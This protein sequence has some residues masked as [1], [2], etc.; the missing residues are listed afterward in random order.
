MAIALRPGRPQA[1]P[2]L[3]V[4]HL[5]VDLVRGRQRT[6]IVR[7]LSFSLEAGQKTAI[8]GE[9]GAGKSVTARAIAGLLDR[10]RFA[11]RGEIAIDGINIVG[12]S[13]R[14]QQRNFNRVALVFQDPTRTLNPT[15]RVGRQIAEAITSGGR[16]QARTAVHARAV[17]LLA[18]VGIA[19]PEERFYLYPHQMSGG[20]RQRVVIAIALALDPVLLLADEATTS[21]DVTTQAQIMDLLEALVETSEMALVLITHDIALAASS[22]DEI[23]VMYAGRFVEHAPVHELVNDPRMPY[24]KALLSAVPGM[25]SGQKPIAIAGQPPD[26][27]ALPGGCPFRPRCPGAIE[28]CEHAEPALHATSAGRAAACWLT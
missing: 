19:D 3:R 6:H 21:L 8:L 1:D 14:Q 2:L 4:D 9:S 27:A 20:M 23:Y 18:T 24:T 7:D 5:E 17:E 25:V 15:M 11:V 28:R 12:L 22:V 16:E 26:L 10:R 13:E